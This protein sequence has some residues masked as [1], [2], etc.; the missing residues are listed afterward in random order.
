MAGPG[1]PSVDSAGIREHLLPTGT[2]PQSHFM[3]VSRHEAGVVHAGIEI[4]RI[5]AE[6]EL[7]FQRVVNIRRVFGHHVLVF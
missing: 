3:A 7:I 1:N 2:D 5:L 4:Y 6:R